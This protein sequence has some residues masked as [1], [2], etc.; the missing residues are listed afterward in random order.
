MS[1]IK[2]RSQSS[3]QLHGQPCIQP[4][5]MI[6]LLL[7]GFLCYVEL[8]WYTRLIIIII[9]PG[10]G[11]KREFPKHFRLE[12]LENPEKLWSWVGPFI[13]SRHN[14]ERSIRIRLS[15]SLCILIYY[16]K[17]LPE[18]RWL[19]IVLSLQISAGWPS[20]SLLCNFTIASPGHHM[21]WSFVPL[22]RIFSESDYH[23]FH[24]YCK[25][26]MQ[27]I[28]KLYIWLTCAQ[29]ESRLSF[30]SFFPL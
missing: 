13:Y 15:E 30:Y 25:S 27:T 9:A 10:N 2:S 11:R 19:R 18:K 14:D 21:H 4:S 17:F 12:S 26:K 6:L 29:W 7:L 23:Q 1:Y 8:D 5:D 22:K 16:Y 24:H 28:C 3:L 20:S